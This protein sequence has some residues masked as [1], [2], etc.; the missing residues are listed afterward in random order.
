M[1]KNY[2][3]TALLVVISAYTSI[4]QTYVFMMKN[5]DGKW[6]FANLKGEVVIAPQYDNCNP[7]SENGLAIVVVDKAFKVINLKGEAISVEV[8]KYTDAA[9]KK[10]NDGL[11]AI[12][13]GDKCGYLNTSGKLAIPLKYDAATDF[14]GG[15]AVV[16]SGTKFIVIDTKG[17][18]APVNESGL[19]EVKHFSEG[20]APARTADKLFGFVNTKGELAIKSQFKSVGYFS[21]GYAWAKTMDDKVGFINTKGEWVLQPTFTS[22]S[23]FDPASKVARVKEIDKWLYVDA[24]GKKIYVN[25]TEHWGDF[26]GGLADGTQLGKDGFYNTKGEWVIKPQ[27]EGVRDFKNG[28]AAAKLNGM[29]GIIDTT[30]KWVVQPTYSGIRDAELIK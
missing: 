18:E 16:K 5:A 4:A 23:D 13:A 17:T 24:T 6:G 12:K 14:D 15:Y 22:A 3:L 30:G 19:L 27:F 20:F 10:F 28:Y 2:F 9:S 1:K 11:F 21:G 25:D 26:S 7:F 8:P 29:W